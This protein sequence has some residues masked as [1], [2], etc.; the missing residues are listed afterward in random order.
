MTEKMKDRKAERSEVSR[1]NFLRGALAAVAVAGFDVHLQSWAT[2]ADLAS[3]RARPAD[4]FPQFDG[5]LLTDRASLKAAADDYG[6]AVHRRPMAVLKP[7]SIEDVVR[8]LDF[9][10]RHGIRVAARGQGHSTQGQAQVRAGVVIDMSTLAA[11]HEINAGD[12]LVDAGLRWS[13]LLRRTLPLR[14]APPTL[15]DYL[16]LSIGGTL[17]VGGVGA[18]AF[19]RG[20]QVDNVLELTVVTGRGQLTTCSAT[21]NREL[22][23][24]VRAGL[25]QFGVIVRARLRLVPALPRTRY[26]KATYDEL[27]VF[28]ADLLLLVHDG[29]FDTVQGF[30]NALPGGGWNYT[31][32]V[33]KNF[34]PGRE[35]DDAALLAGLR[36]LPGQQTAEDLSY[37]DY[38]NRLAP[39]VEFLKQ[40]GV[41]YFPHPW[42]DLLVPTSR[43]ESFIAGTLAALDPADVGQGPIIVYP[44]LGNRFTAP[45]LRV[46]AGETF[47]L[48]GLL[49]TAIPP[50]PERSAELVAANRR[51]FEQ[52]RAVGGFFYPVDSVPMSPA[53]WRRHFGP[54]WPQFH[55]AKQEFDPDALLA[56][57]QGI[58]LED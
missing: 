15:N 10:H 39:T 55:A 54:R 31:L 48:F 53:D 41:W 47:F 29:R 27:P 32:E 1:R 3:G 40:I 7:G 18:Q 36:F 38:L 25:G 51:L 50:T 58:F 44:Y 49:R 5:Q 52:A 11:V 9:T 17:S 26:Y 30:V 22:F 14:L 56:P 4:G 12:A 46:P 21:Q 34:A 33:T 16:D 19:R 24:A 35:P 43:A 20:P 6:H 37:F 23:D 42:V 2:A 45:N 8:L 28:L 57:G 13:D